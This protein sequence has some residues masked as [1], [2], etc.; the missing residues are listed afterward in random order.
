MV[1]AARQFDQSAAAS[2]SLAELVNG[3]LATQVRAAQRG[4]RRLR[5]GDLRPIH[6]TRVAVRRYRTAL[7]V[8]GVLID[9]SAQVEA[10]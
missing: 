1:Q 3:Y 5:D 7:R 9:L 8:F 4:D 2:H 10:A 6:A